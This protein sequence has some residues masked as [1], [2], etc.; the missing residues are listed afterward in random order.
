LNNYRIILTTTIYKNL[1]HK[2][3]LKP[4]QKKALIIYAM[5]NNFALARTMD[6]N[7]VV[8]ELS[9]QNILNYSFR[10]AKRT[11]YKFRKDYQL[12]I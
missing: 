1:A 12:I 6:F 2:L 3:T 7:L 11:F 8:T 9:R 5:R 4:G 10:D